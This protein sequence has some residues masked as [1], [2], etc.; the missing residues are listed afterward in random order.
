ME[1][2]AQLLVRP[3]VHPPR[4]ERVLLIIVAVVAQLS[5]MGRLTVARLVFE[6][7]PH[8]LVVLVVLLVHERIVKEAEPERA[9]PRV[10]RER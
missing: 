9:K 1:L 2:R 3:T 8:V 6:D 10:V 4:V 5:P 7:L